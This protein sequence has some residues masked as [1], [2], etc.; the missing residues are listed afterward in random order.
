MGCFFG[1]QRRGEPH[2]G[3]NVDYADIQVSH[4]LTGGGVASGYLSLDFVGTYRVRAIFNSSR[5][6]GD[7]GCNSPMAP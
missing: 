4:D 7:S 5:K 2:V 6:R 1:V 3:S